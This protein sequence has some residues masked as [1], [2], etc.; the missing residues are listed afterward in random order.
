LIPTLLEDLTNC[1]NKGREKDII[2]SIL[3]RLNESVAS[4]SEVFPLL[5]EM[6]QNNV[7]D[8]GFI[9]SVLRAC[10]VEGEKVLLQFMNQYQNN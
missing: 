5:V 2:L 3:N 10:G 8:R 6:M 9:A 7:N 1:K 4:N